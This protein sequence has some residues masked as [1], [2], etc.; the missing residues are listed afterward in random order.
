MVTTAFL[1]SLIL[2]AQDSKLTAAERDRIKRLVDQR[3]RSRREQTRDEAYQLLAHHGW[4]EHITRLVVRLIADGLRTED[5]ILM[6][7]W[8]DR[9]NPDS[10]WAEEIERRYR[11]RERGPS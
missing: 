1:N 7:A 10:P 9:L 11:L 3:P 4:P 5:R 8:Q 6:H 2:T